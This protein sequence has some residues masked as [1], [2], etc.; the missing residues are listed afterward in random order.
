MVAKWGIPNV[1]WKTVTP[2]IHSSSRRV[3]QF[4]QMWLWGQCL[5]HSPLLRWLGTW[6]PVSWGPHVCLQPSCQSWRRH[7]IYNVQSRGSP[8]LGTF[9]CSPSPF[10]CSHFCWTVSEHH[11]NYATKSIPAVSICRR[12]SSHIWCNG[13]VHTLFVHWHARHCVMFHNSFLW[14]NWW[15]CNKFYRSPFVQHIN[16]L[17]LFGA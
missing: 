14:K 9:L 11:L 16:M 17:M 12:W 4:P 8:S 15:P 10:V 5:Y 7:C 13:C 1:A 3:V 2:T 6:A